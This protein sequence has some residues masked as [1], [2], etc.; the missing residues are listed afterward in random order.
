M[1]SLRQWIED[2]I[3]AV[4]DM[5]DAQERVLRASN[6]TELDNALAS[7]PPEVKQSDNIRALSTSKQLDIDGRTKNIEDP[8]QAIIHAMLDEWQKETAKSLLEDPAKAGE[9]LSKLSARIIEV[10]GSALAIEMA[11]GALPNTEGTVASL[12]VRQLMGWL[13]FG[14]VISAVAHDPVKIGLLR[15]YQDALEAKFRNKRPDHVEVLK[16]YQQR[17]LSPTRIDDVNT[18]DDALMDRVEQENSVAL[19]A[20]MAKHGYSQ[21]FIEIM[22]DAET[23]ALTFSNLAQ[24]AR[25]G[26]YSRPLATFSLWG[27]GLDRR[28]MKA[29]LDTLDRMNVSSQYE[30]F[31]A[32]IEPSY[33][34]G[35]IEE[36]DLIWYWDQIRVPKDIQ[37]KVL[38][39][40]R[41][42]REKALA[43]A[44]KDVVGKEK[45]L[46]V[47][48]LTTAYVDGLV[49]REKA[50]DD[51]IRLGYD[52]T[53]TE[54]LL[55][56]ADT[57][58]KTPSAAKLKRLP[59]SDYEKAWKAN[60]ISADA[61]IARMEGEYD[62]RDIALERQ[63][64]KGGK[65]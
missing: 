12:K 17:S 25:M 4:K 60:I 31:R 8:L 29:A 41:K 44:A 40:M 62:P 28:L 16:A 6:K 50:K 59:L 30:G 39:R 20:E 22:K 5:S 65:A 11:A 47:S 55:K 37:D 61:V 7:L 49:S 57:R 35:S 21:G 46:T 58:R 19:D 14:A 54:I 43:K 24:L 9:T 2:R 18:I 36:S 52:A 1:V 42:A 33:V 38:P 53:E 63:L 26:H 15:P 64:M 23:K 32:M 48:Q 34:D 3:K 45:D 27:Y 10:S 56:I 13:G 51:I